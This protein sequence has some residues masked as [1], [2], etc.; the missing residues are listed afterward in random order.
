M[1]IKNKYGKLLLTI[2]IDL[3]GADLRM[4]ESM[5]T[6][7]EWMYPNVSTTHP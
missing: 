3:H 6:R 1:Q 4:A 5:I 7:I 2:K